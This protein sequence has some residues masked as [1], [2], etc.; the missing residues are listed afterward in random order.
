MRTHIALHRC[1]TVEGRRSK[2]DQIGDAAVV[3]IKE[4]GP[5]SLSDLFDA[6][7]A[8]GVEIG[9][10]NPKQYLSTTLNRDDRLKYVEGKGWSLSKG[11][12]I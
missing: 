3:A 8:S 6:I 12:G 11:G 7:E 1:G 2:K 4:N 10:Q 5:M 9:I